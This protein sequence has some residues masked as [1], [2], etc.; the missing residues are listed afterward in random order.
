MQI[1]RG[2]DAAYAKSKASEYMKPEV[3]GLS[4][5]RLVLEIASQCDSIEQHHTFR[6]TD[7]AEAN[8]PW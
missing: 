6:S 8:T 5:L 4:V 1:G 7:A 2:T 3:A